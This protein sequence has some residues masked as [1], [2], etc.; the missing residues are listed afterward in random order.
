MVFSSNEETK[1]LEL[2]NSVASLPNNTADYII[3]DE[4]S[5]FHIS[6]TSEDLF[7]AII[8]GMMEI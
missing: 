2:P 6:I 8:L 3:D 7:G 5:I 1:T 4:E